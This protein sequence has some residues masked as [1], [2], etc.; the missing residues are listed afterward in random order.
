MKDIRRGGVEKME[1][2]ICGVLG[3]YVNLEERS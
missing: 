1:R 3:V 2:E